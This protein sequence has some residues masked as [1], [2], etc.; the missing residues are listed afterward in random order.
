KKGAKGAEKNNAATFNRFL[1][2]SKLRESFNLNFESLF[3][4]AFTEVP[5]AKPVKVEAARPV[6]EPER[7]TPVGEVTRPASTA[8]AGVHDGPADL[9]DDAAVELRETESQ[10]AVDAKETG[11]LRN[12]GESP[13]E[14]GETRDAVDAREAKLAEKTES[15]SVHV[16]MLRVELSAKL[17]QSLSDEKLA[18]LKEKIEDLLEDDGLSLK[19][20]MAGALN[21]VAEIVGPQVAQEVCSCGDDLGME[22]ARKFLKKFLK[23]LA[24]AIDDAPEVQSVSAEDNVPPAVEERVD[25]AISKLIQKMDR[26]ITQAD[27]ALAR[28][29]VSDMKSTDDKP[30]E[31]KAEKPVDAPKVLEFK[32]ETIRLQTIEVRADDGSQ[33][34]RAQANLEAGLAEAIRA[35]AKA[36]V[37]HAPLTPLAGTPG[38][39]EVGR[40]AR[41]DGQ[42]ASWQN[43]YN[44]NSAMK[45]MDR[46]TE[47]RRGQ[48]SQ[49]APQNPIFEQI[50]QNAKL[51]VTNGKGEATIKLN[52]EFLG[53]VEMKIVVEEGKVNVKFTVENNAV[54][55]AIA[56]NVQDL[57]KNLAES[58]LEVEN[59]TIL[60]GGEFAE[61]DAREEDAQREN[62]P[63]YRGSRGGGDDTEEDVSFDTIRS[64]VE[65]G[66]TVRYVA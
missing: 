57:R 61:T 46:A 44:Q 24:R 9:A 59:V 25:D 6:H 34:V 49:R 45:F 30:V 28:D 12:S 56:D 42:A 47:T 64:V 66:S 63:G 37:S 4:D 43:S 60:L 48:E 54:R 52:P 35:R 8:D 10:D 3:L 55:Q 7:V 32:R 50:V 16:R 62:A 26:K 5:V 65:D 53:K 33:Q 40:A 17:A 38:V 15:V 11:E 20:L 19:Q 58:G 36:P 22:D 14:T 2:S 51:T 23:D 31:V 1:S 13:R 21:I 29:L 27:Q 18:D 39:G 41:A